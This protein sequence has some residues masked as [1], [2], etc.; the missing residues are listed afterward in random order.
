MTLELS[1]I[2]ARGALGITSTLIFIGSLAS[3]KLPEAF[4]VVGCLALLTTSM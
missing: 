4:G 3:F 1:I 2:M